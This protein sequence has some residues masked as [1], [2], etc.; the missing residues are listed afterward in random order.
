VSIIY[1]MKEAK[2]CWQKERFIGF[3]QHAMY[4]SSLLFY[5]YYSFLS[6]WSQWSTSAILVLFY[7]FI[8]VV[9]GNYDMG[10]WFLK[11]F[12]M[13]SSLHGYKNEVTKQ[14]YLT[15]FLYNST[16]QLISDKCRL[17]I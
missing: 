9:L 17:H 5:Y 15:I 11:Q 2:K 8:I 13:N 16:C 3:C 10:S 1:S 4:P 6:F 14:N 7:S 12:L